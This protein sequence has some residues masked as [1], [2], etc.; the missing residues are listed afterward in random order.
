MACI[1]AAGCLTDDERVETSQPEVD[2][3][4][5]VEVRHEDVDTRMVCQCL[6]SKA[7]GIVAAARQTDV[8]VLLLARYDRIL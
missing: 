7:S 6:E 4:K 5:V 8:S 2:T 1:V 3:T